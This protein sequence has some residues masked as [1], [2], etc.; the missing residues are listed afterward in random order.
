MFYCSKTGLMLYKHFSIRHFIFFLAFG[1]PLIANGQLT[2]IM[3]TVANA[4]TD[5]KMPFVNIVFQGSTIGVTTGFD[6]TFSIETKTPGDSLTASFIGFK[7]MKMP[8]KAGIFQQ[9]NFYLEP[10]DF[11]LETV[12]IVAGENP[13]EV[14]LRKIIQ[15]K[16]SNNPER[17]QALEYEAYNKIQIDINNITDQFKQRRV[18]KH[19]DF[20]FDNVDTSTVNGKTY[21]P[22]FLSETVSNVYTRANPKASLEIVTATKTSGIENESVLQFLGDKFQQTNVYDNYI[23]LFQKNFISPVANFALNFYKYYLIDSAYIENQWCYKV[24][25][26]P[27]KKQTLTFNGH[28]WVHDTTFALKEI[29]LRI[30]GDANIN[31][32]NDLVI[33][34]QFGLIDGKN[35]L[36]TKDYI[37][38]D[39]NIFDEMDKQPVGF[40]GRKTTTYRNFVVNM[41]RE[42][43]FYKSPV[44][45]VLAETASEKP[46]SFWIENR[47]EELTHDEKTIYFM[48][49]TLKTI[50][51]FN[52]YIDIIQMLTTGYYVDGNFEIG[53]Y[54][55]VLSF[56]AVE[57]ARFRLG[58]RTSNKFSTRLMLY[59]HV[60]YGTLDQKFKYGG[61]FL[62]MI[63]KNPRRTFGADFR[64]DLEQLG[65]SQNAFREDF[66]LAFLFR[67]NPADKLSLVEETKIHYEHE[68]FN[69]FSNTLNLIHSNIYPAGKTTFGLRM[70]FVD[71]TI[72][73][74]AIT[75]TE[76]RLDTRLAYKEKFVMGEFERVS[77]GAKYPI[78]DIRYGY[79][80]PHSLGGDYEFHKL[81]LS[82]S[83]WFNVFNL[84]WS[85]FIIETGRIWGKIPYP[86][87]KLHE[88]NETY[89]FDEYSF[90][91]MNYFEF[92]SD[93]YLSTYYTHHFDGYFFNRVPLFRKLKW[94]EVVFAKGLIGG[95][96]EKNSNYSVLPEGMFTLS[97]PYFEAGAGI[98]NIFKIIRVDAIWRLAYLDHPN[99]SKFGI[100]FSL[101]FSF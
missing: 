89:F 90:N 46:D 92:I 41:P 37:I 77:L 11:E 25:Y 19:F 7:P 34:K 94:R 29:S 8:V 47:H 20:I 97:K 55:S 83:H 27:R 44:S 4:K 24:M 86:L 22:V 57:G 9:L 1:L 64:Y 26:Q 68:W 88:G 16:N 49:D 96:D 91:M 101:Q 30:A 80:F 56:N 12:V 95:L 62:Y 75:S 5:E 78:L 81:Q 3:G 72:N 98:E 28:F 39:L 60:A 13:A 48:V 100:R 66:L 14:L 6:G 17:H 69:G 32:I 10:T 67:R 52:T 82:A 43:S 2:R 93:K 42:E 70:P 50:P 74:S 53:P 79:G 45:V 85:K 51:R 87:L 63:N 38:G 40:F 35:W 33:E 54:A 31:F 15:N 36:L 73:Q 21:L 84:G 23:G 76:I 71:D 65:A 99:I 18:F 58:G 61:G 59:G